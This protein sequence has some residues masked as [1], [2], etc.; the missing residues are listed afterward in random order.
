LRSCY[1]VLAGFQLLDIPASPSPVP[2][3]LVDFWF[4]SIDIPETSQ[5]PPNNRV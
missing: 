3:N 2:S 4:S 1:A 5:P